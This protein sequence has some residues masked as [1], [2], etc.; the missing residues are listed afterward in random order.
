MLVSYQKTFSDQTKIF[1]FFIDLLNIS[2]LLYGFWSANVSFL[3]SGFIRHLRRLRGTV[4]SI[5]KFKERVLLDSPRHTRRVDNP[6]YTEVYTGRKQ[7]RNGVIA[8]RKCLLRKS[9]SHKSDSFACLVSSIQRSAHL[10]KPQRKCL[11]R[12]SFSYT[13]DSF[14]CQWFTCVFNECQFSKLLMPQSFCLE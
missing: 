14:V 1:V 3:L 10:R 4:A 7:Q 6:V 2:V 5:I 9:F 8:H 13:S 12:K 11:L